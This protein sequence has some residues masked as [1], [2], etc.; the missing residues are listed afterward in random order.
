MGKAACLTA[1]SIV[2]TVLKFTGKMEFAD[3]NLRTLGKGGV[4]AD[5][6]FLFDMSPQ[7]QSLGFRIR[8]NIS[9]L[10]PMKHNIPKMFPGKIGQKNLSSKANIFEFNSLQ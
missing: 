9:N 1:S 2:Y 3:G 7:P 10:C 5:S 6:I 4:R 8:L